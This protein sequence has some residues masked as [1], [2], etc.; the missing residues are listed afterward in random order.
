[1][2]VRDLYD[3]D[4]RHGSTIDAPVGQVGWRARWGKH[5]SIRSPQGQ[6]EL[7]DPVATKGMAATWHAFEIVE[8]RRGLQAA[9][10]SPQDAPLIGAEMSLAG[11]V[12]CAYLA[13]TA[14]LPLNV[15]FGVSL[16]R[17]ITLGVMM[18]A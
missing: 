16:D 17:G 7:A 2:V 1:M 10:A 9:E 6:G 3:L 5:E 12:V 15:D 14:I 18:H 13:E 8:G 11:L 4:G